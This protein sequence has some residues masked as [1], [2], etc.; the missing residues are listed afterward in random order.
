MR[1]HHTKNKGDLGAIKAMAD[2]TAKGWS[3]FVGLSEH[4]AFDFAA[5]REGRFLRVQAKY[6]ALYKGLIYLQ[7]NSNWSDR[8]GTHHVPLDRNAIDVLAIYVPDTDRCYY[9]DIKAH[10]SGTISLR[11]DPCLNNNKKRIR[12]A[13]DFLEIPATVRGISA[14]E[15]SGLV[16]W[17]WVRQSAES[18]A[19]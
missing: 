15:T 7:L 11:F 6:R 18:R 3:V 9:V 13:E 5:Y 8:N 2:M 4:Q 19:A 12:W 10:P 14:G 16:G 1:Y 17:G